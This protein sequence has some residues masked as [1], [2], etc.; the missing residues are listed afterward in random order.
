MVDI[1]YKL[2]TD[3]ST[4]WSRRVIFGANMW[5]TLWPHYTVRDIFLNTDRSRN[6]SSIHYLEVL[7]LDATTCIRATNLNQSLLEML[8]LLFSKL[9]SFPFSN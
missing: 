8:L 6:I 4:P 9:K 3:R 1:N 5:V 2:V 7:V